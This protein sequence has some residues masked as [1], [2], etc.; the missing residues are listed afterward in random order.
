MEIIAFQM[1]AAFLFSQVR[2]FQIDK[3]AVSTSAFRKFVRA[4][5]FKT[6]A[7][8]FGWSFV[9][10]PFV[11]EKVKAGIKESVQVTLCALWFLF[12]LNFGQPCMA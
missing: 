6:E 9:L 11:S 1:I 5:K 2:P 4:T 12:G 8:K 3:Y 7:E 10:E